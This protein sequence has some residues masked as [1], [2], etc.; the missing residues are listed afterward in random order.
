MLATATATSRLHR[1]CSA[2]WIRTPLASA[3]HY[4]AGA[5]SCFQCGAGRARLSRARPAWRVEPGSVVIAPLGPRQ[6]LGIVW[7][8]DSLPRSQRCPTAS[9]ARCS[10]CCRCRRC[11]APLR[12]LIEWTADYYCAPLSAV[13]RMALVSSAALK[14]GGT[15][16]RISPDRRGAGA[17][18]AAARRRDRRAG[19]ASRRRSA[20]WPRSPA[21]PKACC[22]A[23]SAAGLLEPVVVDI[24]RPYPRAPGPICRARTF[25]PISARPADSLCRRRARSLSA[26]FLLDGVTGSGKTECYFEAMAEALRLGGRCWCCCPKSR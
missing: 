26:P 23:W 10:K 17:P 2:G 1:R 21:Y 3:R 6:I 12:R 9:C 18:H 15:D 7:E 22:A 16:H 25:R 20:N 5:T 14:G 19:A 8:P 13:A 4:G 11:R 24:D